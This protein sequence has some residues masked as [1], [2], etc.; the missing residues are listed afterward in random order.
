MNDLN[1][2]IAANLKKI[3]EERSLSLDKVA[4]LTG[5]SKS[6]IGQIERGESNPTITTVW[7]LANGLKISFSAFMSITQ[8]QTSLIKKSDIKP[9]IEDNGKYRVYPFFPY[10]DARRFE[11]YM[12]EIDKGGYWSADG[13]GKNTSEY[14]TVFSGELTVRVGNNEYLVP[15]GDSIRFRA[16]ASHSYHNS[17][18]TMTRLSMTIYYPG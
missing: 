16:D 10:E 8:P 4:E 5:V 14:I 11:M 18:K 15:E 9:L 12:I 13:H 17:G 3:R 2:I 1:T 6:M 7:K